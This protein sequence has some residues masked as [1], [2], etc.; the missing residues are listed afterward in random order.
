MGNKVQHIYEHH[1]LP[2]FE[3]SVNIAALQY[4]D[5]IDLKELVVILFLSV[6]NL[7]LV[8]SARRYTP[9]PGQFLAAQF[10]VAVLQIWHVCY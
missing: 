9:S 1:E 4:Q 2:M 8:C 10:S 3:D 7:G 5:W 6:E